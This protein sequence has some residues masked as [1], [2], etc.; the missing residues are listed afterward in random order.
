MAPGGGTSEIVERDR[1]SSGAVSYPTI[2]SRFDPRHNSLNFLRL[3]LALTV[4]VSHTSGI[5][6]YHPLFSGPSKWFVWND[7]GPGDIAVYGF[8][9]ISGFLIARSATHNGFGRYLWQRFL[10]IF[11]AF[12]VAI[13]LTAFLFSL[14][15]WSAQKGYAQGVS[16][17]QF[18][19]GYQGA[20]NYVVHNALL[21]MNQ[22]LIT[23]ALWN[24]S[25]WTL[26]YEFLCYLLLAVLIL[27]GVMRR[28]AV[29]AGLAAAFWAANFVI[30]WT[31]GLHHY[32]HQAAVNT[33]GLVFV[34]MDFI[35]LAA[36]FLAGAVVYLY[37]DR[38]PDSGWLALVCSVGFL[39]SLFIP[40]H[41]L[42]PTRNFTGSDLLLPLVAYPVI[43]LGMHLPFQR[44]GSR[45]D[46]SYGVY[47]YA[48]PVQILL[49]V[50]GV[51]RWGY[52]AYFSLT[53][54]GTVP[55]AVAS[56][57]L[58]EKRALSLKRYD[59]SRAR[60]KLLGPPRSQRAASVV[61]PQVARES[62]PPDPLAVMDLGKSVE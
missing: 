36:I 31:P 11:P 58:I 17:H 56:W 51:W 49:L 39:A 45:N 16:L 4:V 7:T 32:F 24:G 50:W 43:W 14:L 2:E 47:I 27:L 3:F 60:V 42:L 44:I 23:G 20:L 48:F 46:Y 29:V 61:E 19:F 53:V 21:R 1:G 33:Q 30:T 34:Q 26:F 8:F 22:L 9:G 12:W 25:L 59:F 62:L 35:R 54:L 41:G 15:G 52:V 28:R 18:V 5:A 37:R 55:F 6:I 13:V 40:T 38:I 57:W 10:R